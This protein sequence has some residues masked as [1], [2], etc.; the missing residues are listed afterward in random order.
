MGRDQ[1]GGKRLQGKQ[2]VHVISKYKGGV[3]GGMIQARKQEKTEES[4]RITEN[5]VQKGN[6]LLCML[7]KK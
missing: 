7:V 1:K 2:W 3:R 5:Y 6:V 4:R